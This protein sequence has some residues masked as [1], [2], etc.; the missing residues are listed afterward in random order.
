MLWPEDYGW[1]EDIGALAVLDGAG[2]LDDEGWVRIEV[3]RRRLEPKLARVPRFRQLLY[4]PLLGL[5][6]PL[7]VDA[8]S[9]DLADHI[10]V[11]SVAAPGDEAQLLQTCEELLRRRLD[12][13][14]P[15][16]E[17]WFLP[18][19]PAGRVGLFVKLHHAVAD[20]V[21]GI[22][23][24]GALL[25]LS[26]D[27]PAAQ[28]G[29]WAPAPAPS[30]ARLPPRQPA[31]PASADPSWADS[32]GPT[33]QDSARGKARTAV[34]RV[35]RLLPRAAHPED[36]AWRRSSVLCRSAQSHH[37][38]RPGSLPRRGCIRAGRSEHPR[39]ADPHRRR[40]AWYRWVGS[41]RGRWSAIECMTLLQ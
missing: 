12:P 17:M 33:D 14:R 22:A 35:L 16:W 39:R 41:G 31:A 21:A 1:P 28:A 24:L 29:L 8:P 34:A 4:R 23:T 37:C 38:R 18:G 10:R 40:T 11:R 32:P 20:G 7:W 13:V 25:D 9:F 30:A 6:W 27:P 36:H 3:V 15:L 5:G 26:A 2:L 19:L